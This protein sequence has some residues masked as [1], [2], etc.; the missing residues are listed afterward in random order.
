MRSDIMYEKETH[1]FANQRRDKT[2]AVRRGRGD[3][4]GEKKDTEED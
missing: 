3:V 2:I 4:E 1:V